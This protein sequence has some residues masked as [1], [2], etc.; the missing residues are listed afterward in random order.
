MQTDI[1]RA[2]MLCGLLILSGCATKAYEPIDAEIFA[3]KSDVGLVYVA[4]PKEIYV[5]IVRGPRRY[6]DFEVSVGREL[7]AAVAGSALG[8]YAGYA[9]A[10][11]TAPYGTVVVVNPVAVGV[12]LASPLVGAG[13]EANKQR[14]ARERAEPFQQ[15][16]ETES[17]SADFFQSLVSRLNSEGSFVQRDIPM[18]VLDSESDMSTKEILAEIGT[19]KVIVVS[20]MAAFTPRFEALEATGIYGVIDATQ[21]RPKALYENGIVVQSTLRGLLDNPD[22]QDYVADLLE[23]QRKERIEAAMNDPLL[24]DNYSRNREVRSIN[25]KAKNRLKR[26]QKGYVPFDD[27]DREGTTWQAEEGAHFTDQLNKIYQELARLIFEDLD[28]KGSIDSLDLV[29]PRGYSRKMYKLP[30]LSNDARSV[31]RL[32]TGQLISTPKDGWMV[33]LSSDTE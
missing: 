12:L 8:I 20:T 15:L 7:L 14:G 16:I 25:A 29:E 24:R 18:M 4:P 5:E 22:Q 31:Y 1:V 19:S 10:V 3:E 33:P 2:V 23:V 13:I 6:A 32:E 9:Y 28:T 17:P 21:K 27:G 30:D 11:A 26:V